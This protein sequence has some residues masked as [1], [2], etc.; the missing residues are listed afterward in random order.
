MTNPSLRKT[1]D[2]Y[3]FQR[4]VV[5]V[6]SAPFMAQFVQEHAR[7]HATSLTRAAEAALKSTYMDDTMDG[8]GGGGITV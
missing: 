5:G 2:V 7:R 4:V 3:E 1:P 8:G 6:N